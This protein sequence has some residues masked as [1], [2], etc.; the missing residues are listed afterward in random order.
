M[1]GGY[2]IFDM[3]NVSVETGGTVAGLY[4]LIES[5]YGKPAIITNTL[6]A[7]G[8][9]R[10][11]EYVLEYT[12]STECVIITNNYIYTVA[13]DDTVTVKKNNE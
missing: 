4:D 3:H 6:D 7:D 1:K 9:K 2:Q 11:D 13:N 12:K 10:N 8:N 5:T